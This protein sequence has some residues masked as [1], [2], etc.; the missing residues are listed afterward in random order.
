[1]NELHTLFEQARLLVEQHVPSSL[2]A[3]GI[4]LAIG[5]VVAGIGLSVFGA[6]LAR[7]GVTAAFVG[8][9]GAIGGYFSRHTDYPAILCM[10]AGGL[11]VGLVAYHTFRLWVGLA[12]A[13]VLSSISLGMFGYQRVMPHLGEFKETTTWSAA[14]TPGSFVVPTPDEQQAF[15]ERTPAEWFR[16]LW[17]FV[18]EKDARLERNGK[19]VTIAAMVTGLCLGVLAMRFALIL[20]TSLVGTLLVTSGLFKLLAHI[21]PGSYQT[22]QSR[23]DVM[24]MA[25]GAFLVTSLILQTLLTRSSSCCKKEGKAKS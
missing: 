1:M 3:Q 17:T 2:L 16:Q 13:V 18:T 7:L 9:G 6:K 25:I 21:A 15:N 5:L 14:E 10:L 24:G 4:P 20:S 19:A 11:M 23:P 8:V 12:A 22:V